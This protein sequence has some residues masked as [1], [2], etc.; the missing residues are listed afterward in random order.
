LKVSKS[1]NGGK[2]IN[3]T[4]NNRL[5]S[6]LSSILAKKID[7]SSREAVQNIATTEKADESLLFKLLSDSE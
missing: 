5:K 6:G 7:A 3:G 4:A 1:K 2:I